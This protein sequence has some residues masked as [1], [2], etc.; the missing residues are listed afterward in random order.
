LWLMHSV[1]ECSEVKD[2]RVRIKKAAGLE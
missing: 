2:C 1:Y